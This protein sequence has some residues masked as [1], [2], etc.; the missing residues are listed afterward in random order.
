MMGLTLGRQKNRLSLIK[1]FSAFASD[2]SGAT[3]IEYCLILSLIF[4]VIITGFRSVANSN[5]DNYNT[6][7][8]TIDSAIN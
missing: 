8:T 3:A 6:I 2:K 5:S 1:R 4:L 7:T